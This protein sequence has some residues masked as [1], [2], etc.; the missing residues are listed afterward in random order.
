MKWLYKL[1]GFKEVKIIEAND[2][3]DITI[4]PTD[5]PIYGIGDTVWIKE[6]KRELEEQK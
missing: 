2:M 6:G 5:D 3:A 4:T 1:L